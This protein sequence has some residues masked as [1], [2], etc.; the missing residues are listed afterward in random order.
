MRAGQWE[1]GREDGKCA[2]IMRVYP[3][4]G[5]EHPLRASCTGNQGELADP[6]VG[7]SGKDG[8]SS[9]SLSV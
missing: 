8:T 6:L 7:S 3:F 1:V 4:R 5:G 2:D 9:L